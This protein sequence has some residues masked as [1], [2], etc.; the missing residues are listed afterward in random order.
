MS[1]GRPERCARPGP[2]PFV[3]S[4]SRSAVRPPRPGSL[5]L[6]NVSCPPARRLACL[7][8]TRLASDSEVFGDGF[9]WAG[10]ALMFLL[11]QSRRFA[12]LDFSLHMLAVA[13]YDAAQVSRTAGRPDR[14]SERGRRIAATLARSLDPLSGLARRRTEQARA[15]DSG[16]ARSLVR[17]AIR[18][19]SAQDRESEGA[20]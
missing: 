19:G 3:P 18:A 15:P 4:L 17:P 12:M 7:R 13:D 16:H 20:G 9:A 1:G 8:Q 5:V 2:P 11:G 14:A 6:C 10:Q